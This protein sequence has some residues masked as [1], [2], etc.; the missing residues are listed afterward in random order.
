MDI[1]VVT[2]G[3][4]EIYYSNT[5]DLVSQGTLD[6]DDVPSEPGLYIENIYFP[7]DG[8]APQGQY[9]VWVHNYSE[10]GDGPDSWEL[11]VFL[12]NDLVRKTA[13]VTNNDDRSE[14]IFYYLSAGDGGGG[15]GGGGVGGGDD[16]D[17]ILQPLS[18][19]DVVVKDQ[20]IGEARVVYVDTDK[21]LDSKI[22]DDDPYW[23]KYYRSFWRL[24]EASTT[25]GGILSSYPRD[26]VG[27]DNL[28]DGGIRGYHCTGLESYQRGIVRLSLNGMDFF[29]T[30]GCD[31]RRK[32][33]INGVC[34]V[35][36]PAHYRAPIGNLVPASSSLG[37]NYA[38]STINTVITVNFFIN[39]K[40]KIV[41]SQEHV[42][43]YGS[44]FVRWVWPGEV[45]HDGWGVI[46]TE[47]SIQGEWLFV[48]PKDK[49]VAVNTPSFGPE[50]F[51]Q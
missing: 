23:W 10:Q 51:T 14:S 32:K 6:K 49:E 45:T 11:S 3:G 33:I 4:V 42:G 44:S 12:G 1:H 5:F 36:L 30:R 25:P 43:C 21:I 34:D 17:V 20:Q 7:L 38:G 27:G 2:P 40:E 31:I 8:S 26:F 37:P 16:G 39:L 22:S 47:P 28:Y 24:Q 41:T 9:E 35:Y 19:E 48:V 18:F 50:I 15:G 46:P 13:G 29:N